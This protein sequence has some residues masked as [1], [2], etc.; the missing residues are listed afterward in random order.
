MR[1]FIVFAIIFCVAF[2][3]FSQNVVQQRSANLSEAMG[4]TVSRST[5]KL[6]DFDSQIK[7]DGDVKMYTSYKRKYEFVAAALQDSESRLNLL[8]RTNDRMD[9]IK[10]ERDNYEGLLKELQSIKSEFDNHMRSSR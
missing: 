9:Y 7:D 4:T 6:A 5:S 10:S 8:L 2:P 3:V 1:F